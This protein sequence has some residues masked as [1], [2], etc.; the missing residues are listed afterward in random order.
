MESLL[1]LTTAQLKQTQSKQAPL[2]ARIQL[3]ETLVAASKVSSD[4]VVSAGF[5]GVRFFAF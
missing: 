4:A 5:T 3:L 2:E 1:L